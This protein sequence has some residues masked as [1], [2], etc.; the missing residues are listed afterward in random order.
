MKKTFAALTLLLGL[1]AGASAGVHLILFGGYAAT[2]ESAP[3][4]GAVIG[5]GVGFRLSPMFSL[6]ITAGRWIIPV[7]PSD[8][9][10]SRGNLT[11]IPIA[12]E[13]RARFPLDKGRFAAYAAGGLGYALHSF[14]LHSDFAADWDEAGFDIEERV[15]HG[16]AVHVGAGLEVGLGPAVVLDIGA[17]YTILRTKGSWAMADLVGGESLGGPLDNLNFDTLAVVA[18]FRVAFR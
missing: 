4:D 6:D 15:D 1:G 9:G 5:A 13:L 18:G 17:K 3:G 2:P 12:L 8:N 11:E 7:S 10:L 16:L 14:A